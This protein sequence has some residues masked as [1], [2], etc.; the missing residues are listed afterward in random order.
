ELYN[1]N[2]PSDVTGVP[3]GFID[4]DRMTSG[5]QPGDLIIVAGRPSMGKAQPLDARVRTP[6]GWATMGELAVGDA[7]ASV[8]GAPSIVTGVFPQGERQ[9]WRVTFSDGRS[10]ECCDEH[11]WTVHHRAWR[12]PRTVTLAELRAMLGKRR[13]QQRLWI[14]MPS[15]D[16]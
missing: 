5:M 1:Q 2:N 13:Y 14:D 7:L 9:I 6:S 16:F 11:L 10:A 4:L 12:A 8:D 3:T 15:G